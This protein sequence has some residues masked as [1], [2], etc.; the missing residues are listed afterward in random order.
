[1]YD[2]SFL[3]TY[4]D[5]LVDKYSACVDTHAEHSNENRLS[6]KAEHLILNLLQQ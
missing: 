3:Y 5:L 6:P 1:M 2:T 4:T